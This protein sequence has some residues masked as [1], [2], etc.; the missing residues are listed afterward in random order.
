VSF[1]GRSRLSIRRRNPLLGQK[2][3]TMEKIAF[4]AGQKVMARAAVRGFL[5]IRDRFACRSIVSMSIADAFVDK[6]TGLSGHSWY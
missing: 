3:A 4:E 6:A 2:N 5:P 1:W